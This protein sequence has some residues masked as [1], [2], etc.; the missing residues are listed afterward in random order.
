MQLI[1]ENF[2][3]IKLVNFL[4]N[5]LFNLK[6]VYLEIAKLPINFH[7]LI[8]KILNVRVFG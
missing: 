6:I 8:E 7:N 1:I 4:W 3:I 5:D 2:F